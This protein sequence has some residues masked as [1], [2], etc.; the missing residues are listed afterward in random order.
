V[1]TLAKTE[2]ILLEIFS[3]IIA[4]SLNTNLILERSLE[5]NEG[6]KI[7]LGLSKEFPEIIGNTK[8]INDLL[9]EA[10]RLSSFDLPVL[11]TGETGT[12]KELIARMLHFCGNRKDGTFVPVNCS[13]FTESLI[14]SEF[15]GHEKGSF[16]GAS[17]PRMGL[18]E[19]ANNGTLFLD[20]IGEM[21]PSMQAKLLRVLQ[22]GEFRKVGGNKLLRTNARIVMAT[23]KD[24]EEQVRRK[25][26][27]EDLFY[28]INGAKLQV[29]PLRERRDDIRLL[30]MFFL[31]GAMSMA[32]KRIRG[33]RPDTITALKQY[34][35]PGNVRQLKKEIE[36]IV[37][38]IDHDW[39]L[40][41]D[42]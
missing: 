19:L 21:P 13:A 28:R 5:D 3:S 24:L 18:F 2:G 40:V 39:I 6:Y 23:N 14:E 9:Q 31:K 29:P 33:F 26:F 34:N 35:W 36:R 32:R 25:Q 4:I 22:D 11:I 10:F 12:G 27:R 37:A 30:A 20:E 41:S 38:H 8:A 17:E 15:F 1:E 16:T 7:S 42:L